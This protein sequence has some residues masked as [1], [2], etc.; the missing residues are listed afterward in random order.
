MLTRKPP[1]SFP[2]K[3]RRLPKG[4]RVTIALGF[5]HPKGVLLCA[6]TE[7]NTQTDLKIH[8]SKVFE[9]RSAVGR[10]AAVYA[11]NMANALA[12][13]Q[14][15]RTRV[16]RSRSS[17]PL[18]VVEDV[19]EIEY[20]RLVNSRPVEERPDLHFQ[21][22]IAFRPPKGKALLYLTDGIALYQADVPYA[23]AGI[24]EAYALHLIDQA[25]LGMGSMSQLLALG[26][27]VLGVAKRRVSKCGG[28][29]LFIN[30]GH[31]G[32]LTTFHGDQYLLAVENF[33]SVF[34]MLAY[35]LFSQLTDSGMSDEHFQMNFAQFGQKLNDERRRWIEKKAIHL[36]HSEAYRLIHRLEGKPVRKAPKH[37]QQG[38]PPSRG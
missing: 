21:F 28:I 1:R 19:L 32:V 11:G 9:F 12:T 30:L 29:S 15:M 22:I 2:L 6:D 37:G 24:G 20:S 8:A 38:Q 10:F 35:G 23:A 4:R 26:A 13:L 5:S 16:Q 25:R 18:R 33:G 7:I 17:D 3:P 14:K 27:Y 31:D 34:Q 36:Q